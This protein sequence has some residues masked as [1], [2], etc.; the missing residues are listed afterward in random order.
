MPPDSSQTSHSC[1]ASIVL[2]TTPEAARV[3]AEAHRR[4]GPAARFR[5]ARDMSESFRRVALA[6]IHRQH[7]ELSDAQ[8]RA[9]LVWELYGVRIPD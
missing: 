6:R 5:I 7:P 9:H 3:Q 1:Y 2:D 8:C 4:M